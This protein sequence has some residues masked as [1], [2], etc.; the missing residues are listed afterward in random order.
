MNCIKVCIKGYIKD[1]DENTTV[2]FNAFG[3]KNENKINYVEKDV[4]NKIVIEKEKIILIR[5]NK[6]F[7][8]TIVFK[9]NEE[10]ISEYLLKE[11]NFVIELKIY[12]IQ[13][14]ISNNL[15]LINYLVVD[16]DNQYEFYMEMSEKI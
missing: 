1:V 12:T 2:N 5:E 9:L 6:E 8:N 10:T 7:K 14:D 11:N 13:M 16:S 15:L 4:V 3:I